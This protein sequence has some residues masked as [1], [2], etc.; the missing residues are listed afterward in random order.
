MEKAKCFK[1]GYVAKT[2]GLKGEVTIMYTDDADLESIKSVFVEQNDNLVPYFI[3]HVS[4]RLDKAFVK[5]EDVNT[6]EAANQ[7][8]GCS[9]YL[10]KTLRPKLKKGEFYDDEVIDFVVEDEELGLLGS[11]KEVVASGP[12]RL[13]S[14]DY[15]GKEV[16]V[17]INGPFIQSVNKT[18]KKI[19]VQLPDGFLDL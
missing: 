17:P 1:I 16:L 4:S 19:I 14:I 13:L 8:K 3:D 5:F 11:I 15:L 7:L 2:H 10:D 6:L 9:V 18:K 12:N